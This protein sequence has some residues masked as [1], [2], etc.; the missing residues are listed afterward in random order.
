MLQYRY[1][2]YS[3]STYATVHVRMLQYC[4]IV[5][6]VEADGFEFQALEHTITLE[7]PNIPDIFPS[8]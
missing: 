4:I 3:I 8:K 2:C 1:V 7:S 6:Q 5:L